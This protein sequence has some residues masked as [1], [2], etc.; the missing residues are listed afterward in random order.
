MPGPVRK[1]IVQTGAKPVAQLFLP[2]G[3]IFLRDF[4][5]GGDNHDRKA[6]ILIKGI[7]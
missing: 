6:I 1:L 7:E 5:P 3:Q 4:T 2:P